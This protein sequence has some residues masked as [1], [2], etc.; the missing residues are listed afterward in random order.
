MARKV[1]QDCIVQPYHSFKHRIRERHKFKREMINTY[2]F[3]NVE[4]TETD[5]FDMCVYTKYERI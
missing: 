4:F 3:R 2:G 5:D 1:M